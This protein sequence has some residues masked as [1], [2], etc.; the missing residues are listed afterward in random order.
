MIDK[1]WNRLVWEY[2]NDDGIAA[3]KPI[4]VGLDD[5]IDTTAFTSLA[6]SVRQDVEQAERWGITEY[7]RARGK[8]SRVKKVFLTEPTSSKANFPIELGDPAHWRAATLTRHLFAE[9]K[10]RIRRLP[11]TKI[12]RCWLIY[13]RSAVPGLEHSDHSYPTF[14]AEFVWIRL[15]ASKTFYVRL[16]DEKEVVTTA[17]AWFDSRQQHAAVPSDE[18]AVS[19]RVDGEFEP[20]VRQHV[21]SRYEA[22]VLSA[23]HPSSPWR[24]RVVRW[25]DRL[26]GHRLASVL[27]ARSWQRRL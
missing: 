14:Q 21:R 15:T 9:L 11:F 20:R 17:S 22:R 13:S 12:G 10:D 27:D 23:L 4:V 3:R 16:G 7:F 8:E 25:V 5:V 26:P 2:L 24:R 6:D 18:F 1:E 19:L